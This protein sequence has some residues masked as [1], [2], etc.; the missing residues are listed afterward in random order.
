MTPVVLWRRG[1]SDA[2]S[3]LWCRASDCS[4]Q[5][6]A[7]ARPASGADVSHGRYRGRP[8]RRA[9]SCIATRRR[10]TFALSAQC[11]D[12]RAYCSTDTC[13]ACKSCSSRTGSS[14]SRSGGTGGCART[15][16]ALQRGRLHRRLP[17]VSFL[18]LYLPADWRAP[19][20]LHEIADWASAVPC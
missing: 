16:G 9:G 10:A 11:D 17:L 7:W 18:R 8:C 14:R 12:R 5:R 20:A 2:V 13:R 6:V 1:R 4:W 19:A 3:G 15:G